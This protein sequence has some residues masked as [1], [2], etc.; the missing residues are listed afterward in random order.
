[1]CAG[2]L[3]LPRRGRLVVLSQL[4]WGP[5]HLVFTVEK[6]LSLVNRDSSQ[7]GAIDWSRGSRM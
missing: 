1:M 2:V 4:A 7:H 5:W 3:K 6:R